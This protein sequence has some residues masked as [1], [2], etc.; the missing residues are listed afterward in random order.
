MATG[1][2][3]GIEVTVAAG[4]CDSKVSQDRRSDVHDPPREGREADRKQRH[5]RVAD[6][7]RPV[8]TTAAMV[9]ATTVRELPSVRCR[10]QHFTCVWAVQCSPRPFDSIQV[11]EDARVTGADATVREA[12]LLSVPPGYSLT[13]LEKEAH[14]NRSVPVKPLGKLPGGRCGLIE[15]VDPGCPV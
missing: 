11:V 3:T 15:T 14:I 10:Q 13:L 1:S 12:E 6:E 2:S 5:L 8:G 7:E 4:G 9:L